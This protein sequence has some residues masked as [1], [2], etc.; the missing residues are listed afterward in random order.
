MMMYVLIQCSSSTN[1]HQA[2]CTLVGSSK[3]GTTGGANKHPAKCT[4]IVVQC[5]SSSTVY[6]RAGNKHP[7]P[8]VIVIA[9]QSLSRAG[10]GV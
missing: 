9:R 4:V 8:C 1:K 7:A 3:Y 2:Q 5:S 6:H 10:G